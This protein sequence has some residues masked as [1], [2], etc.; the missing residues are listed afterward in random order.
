M[1]PVPP[2]RRT[3]RAER[4]R[5]AARA[6]GRGCGVTAAVSGVGLV[7]GFFALSIVLSQF[8]GCHVDLGP[9]KGTASRHLPIRVSKT[10]G[11]VDGDVVTVT[12]RAFEASSVVGVTLCLQEAD[13]AHKGVDACDTISGV[14]YAVPGK[15]GLSARFRVPRVITVGGRA[16]DCA[17]RARRCLLVAASASSFDDSGGQALTLARGG[18]P[19]RLQPAAPRPQTDH[20]PIRAT[21]TG[22]LATGTTV[23]LVATGFVPGEPVLVA[24][25][26]DRLETKGPMVACQPQDLGTAI[27]ALVLHGVSGIPDHADAHGVVRVDAEVLDRIHPVGSNVDLSSTTTNPRTPL[28]PNRPLAKGDVDCRTRPGRCSLFVA[29]A[30]D[31]KRSAVLPYAIAGR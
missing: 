10:R 4:D 29:A 21:P 13:T 3:R 7:A 30:A 2:D 8:Q 20:L 14:R 15:G 27:G 12:S 18:P 25:C 6:V 17:A 9:G 31:T 23:D 11:L 19:V 28:D 22:P 1:A 16:Y 24:W 5:A 26:T